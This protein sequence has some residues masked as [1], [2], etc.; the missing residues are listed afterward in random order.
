MKVRELIEKLLEFDMGYDV[1]VHLQEP[2]DKLD[3][4][5]FELVSLQRLNDHEHPHVA[6]VTEPAESEAVKTL[7]GVVKALK[8]AG[9]EVV[10][11]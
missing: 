3:R 1:E 5:G 7:E 10:G 11:P 8:D 2:T 6:L 9:Y 4:N